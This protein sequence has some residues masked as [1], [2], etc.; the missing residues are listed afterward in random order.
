MYCICVTRSSMECHHIPSCMR[1]ACSP[2]SQ[3]IAVQVIYQCLRKL[4]D[5]FMRLLSLYLRTVRMK[6]GSIVPNAVAVCNE[7]VSMHFI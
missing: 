1:H 2:K 3:K 6:I 5:L 4:Q 7:S